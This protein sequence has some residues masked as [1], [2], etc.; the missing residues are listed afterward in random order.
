M[1]TYNTGN[2][3]PSAD[4]RDR[5]DNS[6]T[7]DEVVNGDSA[8]YTTRTG[9]QVISLGGMNSRFNNAQDEREAEF[10]LSQEEK[11][12][13]F[14]SFLEGTGWSSIGAYVAGVV[15]TSHTQTVD[16]LGQPYSLKPSIPASV[17]AP[18]IITGNWA[19]ESVK[20][21][22]VG[23]NSLRQDLA[24]PL[25]GGDIVKVTPR[26]TGSVARSVKDALSD[27]VSM[28]DFLTDSQKSQVRSRGSAI[29]LSER[30]QL[31]IDDAFE[32]GGGTII[33]PMGTYDGNVVL[34]SGVYLVS[35]APGF[36][37][38]PGTKTG[39]VMRS[40]GN[41]YVIGSSAS[42]ITAAGTS[43][44]NFKGLG[45]SVPGGG[46]N[47]PN[48]SWCF[49]K[50]A[51]FDNFADHGIIKSLGNA[52][53]FE[54]ILTTNTLLNRSRAD[55]SGCV[56]VAGGADDFLNRIEANPS[57]LTTTDENLRVCGIVYNGSNGFLNSCIG[58]FADVGIYIGGAG[59]TR[60]SML[61]ADL[62]KG[63][64]FEVVS[65]SNQFST[66]SAL[67]NGQAATNTYDGWLVSGTGNQFGE[68]SAFSDG[69]ARTRYGFNDT[70]NT[71][72]SG[73]KN[74]YTNPRSAGSATAQYKTD[75]FAGSAFTFPAAPR[76][77]KT[78]GEVTQ[79]VLETQLVSF[80][81]STPTDFTNFTDG[82]NG[83]PLDVYVTTNNTR[84]IS[85]SGITLPWASLALRSGKSYRFVKDG[86]SWIWL[87]KENP[88]L[89]KA[90]NGDAAATLTVGV[91][92]KTQIWNTPLTGNRG[93]GL[94]GAGAVA[95]DEFFIIRTAAATGAFNLT[96]SGLSVSLSAGQSARLIYDGSRW[97]AA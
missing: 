37:Y 33:L 28:F 44:I 41:G 80:S 96:V 64:G 78:S 13:A 25:V 53:T 27:S 84:I 38:L 24:D 86:A 43:G 1:T 29:D 16:Y 42:G 62:N 72:T 70:V 60:A 12:E 69:A 73:A 85:G 94:S 20:F 83:Q 7:L 39:V 30:M 46:V 87:N 32:N 49:V 40:V 4:A 68:C 2:P 63:R 76:I 9:K 14:Q 92:E 36:R 52:N 8:S 75:D 66:C 74:I 23:D 19:T 10:N 21:K 6:Q 89:V 91:S 65:G 59:R 58:E 26:G 88:N 82:V 54:D 3:V 67:R 97:M 81:D 71:S 93:I 22:L 57:L 50:G 15:I 48:A 56:H 34:K 17:T 77:R 35:L 79:S 51:G 47:L 61:R 5:Y 95:G 55:K 90:D 11:K 18:Y 31:A 45:A